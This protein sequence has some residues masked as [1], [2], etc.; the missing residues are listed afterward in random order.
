MFAEQVLP[1][2]CRLACELLY[3][4]GDGITDRHYVQNLEGPAKKE[5]ADPLARNCGC[6]HLADGRA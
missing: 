5:A 3:Y 1:R 4:P 2:A 6:C